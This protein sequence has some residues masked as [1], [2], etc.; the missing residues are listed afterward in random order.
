MR[1]IIEEYYSGPRFLINFRQLTCDLIGVDKIQMG[2]YVG[3]KSLLEQSFNEYED[4]SSRIL[5]N[6]PWYRSR[7]SIMDDVN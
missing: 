2:F 3:E 6:N 7:V 5:K 4:G 1:D